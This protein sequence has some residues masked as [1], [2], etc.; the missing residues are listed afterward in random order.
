MT[1]VFAETHRAVGL[2]QTLVPVILLLGF[3]GSIEGMM[4]TRKSIRRDL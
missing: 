4:D 3:A 2:I 1:D